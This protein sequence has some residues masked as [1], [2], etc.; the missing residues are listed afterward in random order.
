MELDFLDP[1]HRTLQITL[2]YMC[3]YVYVCSELIFDVCAVLLI[4]YII[5]YMQYVYRY[6]VVIAVVRIHNGALHGTYYVQLL[7]RQLIILEHQRDGVYYTI[8]LYN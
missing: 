6:S 5:S 4:V 1:S 2:M 8:M 3:V 7:L